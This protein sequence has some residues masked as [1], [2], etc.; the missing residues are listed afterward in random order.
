MKNEID[1]EMLL[2]VNSAYPSKMPHKGEIGYASFLE[3]DTMIDAFRNGRGVHY[4]AFTSRFVHYL[5]IP[6]DLSH[7]DVHVIYD[8]SRVEVAMFFGG[9]FVIRVH[10]GIVVGNVGTFRRSNEI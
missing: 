5:I 4:A 6:N 1:G 9:L 2:R 10:F 7:M 3:L 8:I